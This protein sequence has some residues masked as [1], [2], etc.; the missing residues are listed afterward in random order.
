MDRSD[1]EILEKTTPFQGY[2]RID[3]Y[4]LRHRLFAGGWSGEM[5]REIFERGHAVGLLPYDPVRDELV[6]IE[7]FRPGA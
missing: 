2:F 5:T 3:R 7:Q 1:V 6:L 4:C